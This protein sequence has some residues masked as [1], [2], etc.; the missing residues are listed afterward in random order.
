MNEEQA[1]LSI[2]VHPGAGKN[3]ITG[4]TDGVLNVKITTRPEKGKANESLI[5]YLSNILSIAKSNIAIQK[6]TTSRNKLIMIQG[7]STSNAISLLLGTPDLKKTY[8]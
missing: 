5:K 6:G 3:M 1:K 7:I 8:K 2:R 4:Y